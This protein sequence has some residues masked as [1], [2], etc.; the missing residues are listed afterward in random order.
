MVVNR[1]DF[2]EAYENTEARCPVV[3]VLDVS[4]SMTGEPIRQL[5]EGLKVLKKALED[6]PTAS[7]RVE[8][9]VVTFGASVSLAHDFATMDA[10]NPPTLSADGGTPMGEGLEYALQL[11]A[12]RKEQYKNYGLKYYQPWV[13]LITDGYPN[14]NSP[15]QEAAQKIHQEHKN[16]KISFFAVAVEGADMNQLKQVSPPDRTPVKLN[17][18]DFKTMFLWLSRSVGKTAS[19]KVGEEGQTKLE[20]IGWGS[21]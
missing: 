3:L 9:A 13:W 2:P 12:E 6:D 20:P 4:G 8:V 5:N 10:F 19:G 21:V 7:L 17:G 16:K 15:W 11:V 1:R 18:L 14:G